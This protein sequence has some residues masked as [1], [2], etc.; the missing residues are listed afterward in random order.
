MF[1]IE[2]EQREAVMKEICRFIVYEFSAKCQECSK[3]AGN[4]AYHPLSVAARRYLF[5]LVSIPTIKNSVLTYKI[6][7]VSSLYGAIYLYLLE[8]CLMLTSNMKV[9]ECR[10]ME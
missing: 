6:N 4:E 8:H 7:A 2:T 5:Y 9:I 3:A 1:G 10:H